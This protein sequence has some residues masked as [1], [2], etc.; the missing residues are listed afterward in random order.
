MPTLYQLWSR[1]KS[2]AHEAADWLRATAPSLGLCSGCSRFRSD[3]AV[4][5]PLHQPLDGSALNFFWSTGV[6]VAHADL[7]HALG[8]EVVLRTLRLGNV[9]GTNGRRIPDMRTFQP[10]TRVTIRGGLTST[11]RRRGVCRSILY[12]PVR[13]HHLVG[14]PDD[15]PGL[16]GTNLSGC[17]IADESIVS[18]LPSKRYRNLGIS[19]M[20]VSERPLDGRPTN[21]DEAV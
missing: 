3:R 14:A 10:V 2:P 9:L 17:L 18:R 12:A 5:I 20:L 7:L 1:S 16:S 4:D 13:N 15:F 8:N 11:A 21:L 6:G 19:K